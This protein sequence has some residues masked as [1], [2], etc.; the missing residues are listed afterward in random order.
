MTTPSRQVVTTYSYDS[1]GNR[2]GESWPNGNTVQHRYDE[3]VKWGQAKA[4]YKLLSNASYLTTGQDMAIGLGIFLP[5]GAAYAGYAPYA[6]AAVQIFGTEGPVSIRPERIRLLPEDSAEAGPEQRT[7]VGAVADVVHA[8]AQVRY[9]VVLDAGPVFVVTRP[10]D[11]GAA[12]R[13]WPRRGDRVRLAWRPQSEH[14]L[15]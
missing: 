6:L 14:P 11:S 2:T 1:V 3:L 7:T 5:L 13:A 12:D 15:G 4:N 10:A 8:G 9:V